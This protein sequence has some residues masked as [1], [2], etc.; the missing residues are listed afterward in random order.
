MSNKKSTSSRTE[1]ELEAR[2]RRA[3]ARRA[4]DR[5]LTKQMQALGGWDKALDDWDIEELARG[6]P[7]NIDGSFTGVQPK[8][9]PVRVLEE[10]LKRFKDMTQAD[11]RALVPS[12]VETL[13]K[14][15]TDDR[16]DDRGRL[17]IPASVR[18]EAAK[19]VIEHLVGKPTQRIEGDISVRLQGILA[20]VM[21][22]PDKVGNGM[23]PAIEAESWEVE[24]ENSTEDS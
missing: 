5:A 10:A 12:A 1:E 3:K 16:L 20:N 21:V 19:W 11:I 4:R 24:D 15:I 7:R 23:R 18:L 17:V 6:R 2:R 9:I 14:F 8:V 22:S 13:Q